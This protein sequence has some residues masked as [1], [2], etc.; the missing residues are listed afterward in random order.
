MK[1][2]TRFE[3]IDHGDRSSFRFQKTVRYPFILEEPITIA[4]EN[5]KYSILKSFQFNRVHI[6][7]FSY[8]IT[9]HDIIYNVEFIKGTH[10]NPIS[11]MHHAKIIY[12]DLVDN[13]KEW[14]FHD[15]NPE[16][17]IFEGNTNKLYLV[18]FESFEKMT[19]K[20]KEIDH[21]KT[22]RRVV[23]RLHKHYNWK[24]IKDLQNRNPSRETHIFWK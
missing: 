4:K 12:E 23:S 9:G 3:D 2:Y 18:D 19:L 20:E 5:K 15:L 22:V 21:Q 13:D 24:D 17:F 11:F 8:E 1:W 7:D 6:P 14:G 10:L 16:D